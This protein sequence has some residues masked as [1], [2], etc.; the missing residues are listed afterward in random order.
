M[1]DHSSFLFQLDRSSHGYDVVSYP[2]VK[3]FAELFCGGSHGP[4]FGGGVT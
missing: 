2:P 3:A 4:V 1:P